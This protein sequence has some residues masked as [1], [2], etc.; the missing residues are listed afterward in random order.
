MSEGPRQ[1][2]TFRLPRGLVA[3]LQERA[4]LDGV[5]QTEIVE[6]AV[7]RALA[8]AE[9]GP[10][11]PLGASG[12]EPRSEA[13]E[14]APERAAAAAKTSASAASGQSSPQPPMVNLPLWLAE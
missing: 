3:S 11:R 13:L 6:N 4:E 5:S 14:P 2:K 10:G 12:P 1:P 7:R 9:E 8:A